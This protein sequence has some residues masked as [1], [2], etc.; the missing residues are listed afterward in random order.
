MSSCLLVVRIWD[1]RTCWG[2]LIFCGSWGKRVKRMCKYIYAATVRIF[3]PF[4]CRFRVPGGYVSAYQCV[5]LNI[6]G[7]H[8]GLK[9]LDVAAICGIV[10]FTGGGSMA[11]KKR[12]SEDSRKAPALRHH[13][14]PNPPPQP[15]GNALSP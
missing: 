11:E 3:T 7:Q 14:T 15:S 10:I 2:W 5:F 9:R 8:S 6:F 1:C 4:R 13:A 12:R